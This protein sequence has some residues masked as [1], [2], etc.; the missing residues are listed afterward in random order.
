MAVADI[1]TGHGATIVFG[2]TALTLAI[3][4]IT[5]PA[6]STPVLDKTTL[7]TTNFREKLSGDLREPGQ[8]TVEVLFKRNH[9]VATG[10]VAQTVTITWPNAG[11]TAA[12]LAGT[13]FVADFTPGP[14]ATDE[15]QTATMVVQ[16]DGMTGP[17]FSA[18]A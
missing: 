6:W 16:Y 15:L 12:N 1:D 18:E 4:S 3:T 13:A 5:P 14:L 10:G 11:A 2:T 17:T 7:G 8:A 9:Y